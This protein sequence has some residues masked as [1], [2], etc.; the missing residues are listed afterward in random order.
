MSYFNLQNSNLWN[1]WGT[2]SC[3]FVWNM[4]RNSIFTTAHICFMAAVP[5]RVLLE[6]Q[7]PLDLQGKRVL[8]V[9]V[10]TM[11]PLE[12]KGSE[13]QQGHL[14][15]QETKGTLEKMA[16]RL[17]GVFVSK[18]Y[19]INSLL[20]HKTQFLTW[21][22]VWTISVCCSWLNCIVY[23]NKKGKHALCTLGFKKKKTL[24]VVGQGGI[25]PNYNLL[26]VKIHSDF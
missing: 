22:T 26:Q 3:V 6:N 15:A 24:M 23:Y 19:H 4:Q 16:Q 20:N 14:A 2:H 8:V 11:E 9:F 12:N 7:D 25:V 21:H 1:S 10:E 5:S 18:R 13:G 17:A